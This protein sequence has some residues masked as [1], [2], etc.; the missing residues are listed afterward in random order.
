MPVLRRIAAAI[1][2]ILACVLPAG[3][4][5]AAVVGHHDNVATAVNQT[6]STAVSDFAWGVSKQRG[7]DVVDQLNAAHAVASCTA[8]GATAIAFQIVIVSGSPRTV[9]P[10]NVAEAINYQCTG[11]VAVAEARQ[12]V[13]VVDEPVRFTA[14]GTRTLADVRQDLRALTEED[15][16]PAQ[17]HAAVER[18]EARVRAVLATELVD[19]SDPSEDA[20]VLESRVLQDADRG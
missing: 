13:R 15:V 16:D 19:R 17:L 14:A 10:R 6:D 2:L 5:Q 20:D 7:G 9:V 18:E 11:C 12:F 1:A 4:A 8:C 3:G